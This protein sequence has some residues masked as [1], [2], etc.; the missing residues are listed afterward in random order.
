M[1]PWYATW[2]ACFI[3]VVPLDKFWNE[4]IVDQVRIRHSLEVGEKEECLC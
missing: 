4:I 3:S 1:F 2:I